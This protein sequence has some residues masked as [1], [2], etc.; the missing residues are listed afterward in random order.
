M[1]RLPLALLLLTA[2]A[3]DYMLSHTS[4]TLETDPGPTTMPTQ[5]AE[6]TNPQEPTVPDELPPE[7]DCDHTS[8][9]IY[10]I[11]RSDEGLYLFDPATGQFEFQFELACTM[12][13]SPGSMGVARDGFAYVRYS[14]NTIYAVDLQSGSCSPT[15][16]A[17]A[18]FGAF[19]MG[20]ATDD[21]DTWRDRLYVA[22]YG[23]LAELDTAGWG[24]S[25][26]GGMPSQ[27]EL[28]GNADGELWAFLPLESPAILAQIDKDTGSLL[29]RM[30]LPGFA[31]PFDIDAFAFATWGGDFYLFVRL[32]G[33]G[34]TTDVYKVD[35]SGNLTLFAADTGMDVVGAGVST[36]APTE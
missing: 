5:P 16:Y 14:D 7:D 15:T 11:D 25:S 9:L 23:E 10:V 30:D 2:C 6:P 1:T 18:S 19:G 35:G 33:M 12:W 32:F 24:L 36:C 34:S 20:F 13:G 27:S 29:T 28:T 21:G 3:P 8:D 17:G 26:L 22:N 4:T 31:N